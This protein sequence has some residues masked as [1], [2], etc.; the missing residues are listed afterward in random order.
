MIKSC[1]GSGRIVP[2]NALSARSERSCQGCGASVGIYVDPDYVVDTVYRIARHTTWKPNSNRRKKPDM[3]P[4]LFEDASDLE[5]S[6]D[7]PPF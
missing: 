5:D 4:L 6:N 2:G 3:R 1:P 7:E